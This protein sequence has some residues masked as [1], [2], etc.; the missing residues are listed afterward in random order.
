MGSAL[1]TYEMKPDSFRPLAVPLLVFGVPL[2][3]AVTVMGIRLREGR[4]LA[5]GDDSH[6]SH[7]LVALGMSRREAV[8]TIWLMS[9]VAGMGALLLYHVPDEAVPLLLLQG[10]GVFA[11]VGLLERSA[12]RRRLP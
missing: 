12:R 11:V 7:R 10:V 3:D 2:F 8:G 4:S 5:M 9:F 1:F 6:F